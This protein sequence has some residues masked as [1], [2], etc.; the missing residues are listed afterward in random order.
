MCEKAQKWWAM[1]VCTLERMAGA[2][3]RAR[4]MFHWSVV[5]S[6][7]PCGHKTWT[8]TKAMFQVLEGFHHWAAAA[9]LGQ[10]APEE[11]YTWMSPPL[12]GAL[13]D[14]GL[15]S[16]WECVHHCQAAMTQCAATRPIRGLCAAV[17]CWL[18]I[19]ECLVVPLVAAGLDGGHC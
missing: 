1:V 3:K 7:L 8:F 17:P 4:G 14:A 2:S 16:I 13:V 9:W 11:G 12:D 18:V 19:Q 15:H 5:Q 10:D 6:V